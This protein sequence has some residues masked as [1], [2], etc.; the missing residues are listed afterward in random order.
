MIDYIGNNYYLQAK[1]RVH[2]TNLQMRRRISLLR[3]YE[4]REKEWILDEENW[5]IITDEIP[6][7]IVGVEFHSKSTRISEMKKKCNKD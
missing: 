2:D 4:T 3:M 1:S 7:T 6:N 5:R